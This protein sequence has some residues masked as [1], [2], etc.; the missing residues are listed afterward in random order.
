M[1]V[2]TGRQHLWMCLHAFLLIQRQ[3]KPG[4]GEHDCN[5]LIVDWIDQL[6][7]SNEAAVIRGQYRDMIGAMRFQKQFTPAIEWLSQQGFKEV[8]TE[9]EGDIL[10]VANEH[11][12]CA[13]IYHAEQI[14]SMDI[15]LGLV[16]APL[17][18]LD[19]TKGKYTKWRK[20]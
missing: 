17:S 4:W 18:A 5:L 16:N 9:Q 8:D 13:H 10:L 7:N 20:T 1:F 3:A 2:D 19:T 12:W 6:N 15:K 11:Y 14:W